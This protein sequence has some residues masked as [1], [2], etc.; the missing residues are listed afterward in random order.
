MKKQDLKGLALNKKKISNL[1]TNVTRGGS[2]PIITFS[3]R[4]Q[5]FTGHNFCNNNGRN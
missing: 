3:I 5:C 4:V 1:K 2:V